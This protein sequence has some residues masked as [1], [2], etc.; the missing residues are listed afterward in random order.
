MIKN[1]LLLKKKNKMTT[2]K[3]LETLKSRLI[4]VRESRKEDRED[5]IMLSDDHRK[6]SRMQ[7]GMKSLE[8]KM[9]RYL[10]SGNCMAPGFYRMKLWSIS[11]F[12]Q[13]C[14]KMQKESAFYYECSKKTYVKLIHEEEHLLKEIKVEEQRIY[15]E[16]ID[17]NCLFSDMIDSESIVQIVENVV[18]VIS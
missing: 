17:L 1:S 12:W 15:R 11:H 4:E 16:D 6:Y 7:N 18:Q 2:S 13:Y 5:F 14:E 3:L 9:N 10:A 8:R